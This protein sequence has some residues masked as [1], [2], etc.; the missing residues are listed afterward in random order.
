MGGVDSCVA[1]VDSC[2]A[3]V[4]SCIGSASSHDGGG[5]SESRR[6]GVDSHIDD[7]GGVGSRMTGDM[8]VCV[9]DASIGGTMLTSKA[10]LS[11]AGL[12]SD[13]CTAST[14]EIAVLSSSSAAGGVCE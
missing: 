9:C 5:E 1:G 12:L 2:V 14:A 3:G 7:I 4:D 13:C 10:V 8:D 6:D 11:Y